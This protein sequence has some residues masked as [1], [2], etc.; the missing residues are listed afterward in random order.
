M[1]PLQVMPAAHPLDLR[2]KGYDGEAK[3]LRDTLQG[4]LWDMRFNGTW[5]LT[6]TESVNEVSD[7][8]ECVRKERDSARIHICVEGITYRGFLTPPRRYNISD[9]VAKLRQKNTHKKKTSEKDMRAA[10]ILETLQNPPKKENPPKEEPPNQQLANDINKALE[11][12]KP[13]EAEMAKTPKFSSEEYAAIKELTDLYTSGKQG[14]K[15][16]FLRKMYGKSKEFQNEIW[17]QLKGMGYETEADKKRVEAGPVRPAITPAPAVIPTPAPERKTR[18]G[19][20]PRI[21]WSDAEWDH[22]V[23]LVESMRR[24]N[25]EPPLSVLITRAQAQ[26]PQDR[27]RK[28]TGSKLME[29]VVIKLKERLQNLSKAKD[30]LDRLV[31]KMAEQEALPTK[32]EVI[33]GLTDE[34]IIHH[35]SQRVLD[36]LTPAEIFAHFPAEAMLESIPNPVLMS[37]AIQKFLEVISETSTNFNRAF[38]D[39]GTALRSQPGKATATPSIPIPRPVSFVTGRK[40][41][42]AVVGMIGDQPVALESRLAGRATFNFMDK[43]QA[44]TSV[45]SSSDI[46]V[47]WARFCSHKMQ[48]QIKSSLPSTCRLI[49]H[50]GGIQKL[51]ETLDAML[52]KC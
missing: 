29:P 11:V 43:D 50:H 16:W 25:P 26:F 32:D 7:P 13:P 19:G 30:D 46:V 40:P 52:P 41:K 51:A 1:L 20:K 22:L 15:N 6:V 18:E 24:N 49:T 17:H 4:F 10:K 28:L 42:V 45:P 35:F 23:D 12:P 14:K 5:I 47:F 38:L 3:P 31:Q 33:A 9:V 48:N 8:F 44:K 36:N 27:R 37:S 2:I 34:E 21:D 39:I